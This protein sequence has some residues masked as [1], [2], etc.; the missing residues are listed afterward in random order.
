MEPLMRKNK[1]KKQESSGRFLMLPAEVFNSPKYRKISARAVKLLID[2]GCQYNGKNN[3]DLCC[4][5][6]VMKAKGWRSE[7]TLNNAK[8]ELLGAG[9]IAET[10]KGRRPN[11]CSL[12]GITWKHLNPNSKLDIQPYA[13]PFGAW[14]V[15]EKP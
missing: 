15:D 11:L 2:I 5:W 3:G 9:F 1:A 10:R 13:F 8:K 7:Q 6:K 14:K 4:A 12:Y